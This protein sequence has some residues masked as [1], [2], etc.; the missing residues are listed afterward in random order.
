MWPDTRVIDLFGIGIPIL[1]SPMAGSSGHEMAAAVSEA[2]GLGSLPCASRSMEQIRMDIGAVRSRTSKPFNLNFFCHEF[3]AYDET[4]EQTWLDNFAP[5]CDELGVSP[6]LAASG[7]N[8]APFGEEH[9][10]LVEK[11]SPAVVSFHFGLPA[12]DLVA[13][14]KST[15]CVVIST[16]NTVEEAVWLAERGCDAIIAQGTEAGGHRGMFLSQTVT[17][18]AGTMALVPQIVDAVQVPVIAAGG[19]ADGRGIAAAFALGASG[20]QIGTAYLRTGQSLANEMYRA[21]LAAG[22]DEA[23][24]LTNVFSGRAARG[25]ATRLTQ[26]LG[27]IA[28]TPMAFPMGYG[29]LAPFKASAEAA[30]SVEFSSFLAGQAV[31]LGREGDAGDLTRQL[32]DEAQV[33]F[34]RLSGR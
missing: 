9:C 22:T 24:V 10:Q 18:Q 28:D 31:G 17:E 3:N 34:A 13:R 20:V 12:A 14:V 30:G 15:G 33:Q 8:L 26:D 16:A 5:Y 4:T 23:T 7:S 1:Q 11:L 27:P 6:E 21:R 2:G 32:A 19:I 29:V 25:F